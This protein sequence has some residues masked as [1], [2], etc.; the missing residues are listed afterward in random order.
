MVY[1]LREPAR[2][3]RQEFQYVCPKLYDHR[4]CEALLQRQLECGGF[5]LQTATYG[6]MFPMKECHKACAVL[7]TGLRTML[8]VELSTSCLV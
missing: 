3:E 2:L 8:N 6:S 4:L 1:G 7:L 5:E